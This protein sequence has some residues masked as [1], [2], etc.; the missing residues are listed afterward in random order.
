MAAADVLVDG[1]MLVG[2]ADEVWLPGSAAVDSEPGREASTGDSNELT[3]GG[4]GAPGAALGGVEGG[5]TG[6]TT[7]LKLGLRLSKP[8]GGDSRPPLGELG[9]FDPCSCFSVMGA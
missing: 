4:S 9:R 1:A 6:G 5:S 2:S 3:L 8:A 7:A